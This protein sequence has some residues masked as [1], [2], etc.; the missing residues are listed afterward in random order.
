MSFM[1]SLLWVLVLLCSAA[2]LNAQFD[3]GSIVGTV[4]DVGGGVMPEV[5]ITLQSLGTGISKATLSNASGDYTFSSVPTGDYIVKASHVGFK[6]ASTSAFTVTVGARQ[7]VD[8]T[9]FPANVSQQ[10]IVTAAAALL[11]TDSS[12]RSMVINPTEVL[13]LPLNGRDPA[14]LALVVPGVNKS[15]LEIEGA[16]SREAAYNV[17]G[18]RKQVNS[19]LL[20]GLDNNSWSLN[21]LGF[22]NQET[23]LS[24]D[25]LSEF[26]FTTGNQNAEFGRAAGAIVNEVSKRGSN[27]YHGASW[28]YLR[29]T[30]LNANGPIPATNGQKPIL[31]QNQFGADIGGPIKRG[32]LFLFGD[33]E[34]FRQILRRPLLATVPTAAQASGQF[35][36]GSGKAIQITNPYTKAVYAN[37][38]IP[39]ANLKATMLPGSTTTPQISPLNI[40]VLGLLPTPQTGSTFTSFPLGTQDYDKGD[41]RMDYHIGPNM[42]TFA[43]YSQR[44]FNALDPA[45][46][47]APLSST[48]KGYINQSNKQLAAGFVFQ[49][50]TASALDL[51]A[52]FSWNAGAQRPISTGQPNLLVAAGEPNVPSDPSFASGLNTVAVTGFSQFG[53]NTQLP[54]VVN[55]FVADPKVNYSWL[56]GHHSFKFGYEYIH[57]SSLVS[58]FKPVFGADTYGGKFSQGS[59]KAGTLADGTVDPAYA[60]AWNLADFIFG[61]RSKYELS[62]RHQVECNHRMHFFYGQDDWRLTDKLTLNLGLRYENATPPFETN[63][64]LSNFDPATSPTGGLILAKGGSIYDRAL[65]RRNNLNFAPR[66]GLAYSLGSKMVVRGAYGISYQQFL[67]AA[68]VNELAQNAP[69]SI[70]NLITQYAPA[71]P[72]TGQAVCTSTSTSPLNCFQPVQLGYMTGFLSSSNYSALS[73][74]TNYDPA[75][76]PTTYVQSYQLSVQRQLTRSI[77]LDVGYVGNYGVHEQIVQDYNQA[78]PNVAGA[79]LSL[80]ARRPISTYG[81]IQESF[82]EGPSRYNALE[83][84]LEK[85]YSNGIYIANSFTWSHAQ[86]VAA[87]NQE[88]NNNDS[89]VVDRYDPMGTYTRSAYDRPLNDSLAVVAD[90]PFG[91]GRRFGG[92]ASKPLQFLLGDWQV[93]AL[94]Y[95]IS[96]LPINIT[97]AQTTAQQLS[98]ETSFLYRP[99]LKGNPVLSSGNRTSLGGGQYKYLDKSVIDIPDPTKVS[100]PYGN[101]SRNVARAPGFAD[102]DL[103]LHKRFPLGFE[104]VGL[105]F[106]AEAFDVLNR[107]NAQAPDSVATDLTYGIVSSYFP[108]REIQLALKLVF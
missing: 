22:S 40:T 53:R 21:D 32:K 84:K 14:D 89:P 74:T 35:V 108:P 101:C 11:E 92:S 106:R 49:L 61:A 1:R 13:N 44:R 55:P 60:L 93:T 68:V 95:L 94:N 5:Q 98:T 71:Y 9:F 83:A 96:G 66:F 36:D 86:D 10:T 107:S 78:V 18:L 48:A 43:R 46:I 26:R 80:Q 17:N 29:N 38:I 4:H 23:Q 82:N 79:T 8:L 12:D 67:R 97:Y 62:A 100:S 99:S 91:K 58:N 70:D 81:T 73:T 77:F 16:T 42:T 75:R 37:G 34:G 25:A 90:L 57:Q 104:K 85:R 24:P 50:T 103:G 27:E 39:V 69:Y 63:N 59:A 3:S 72:K 102:L 51:R 52:G 31:I 105:E 87:A 76:T 30:V 65:I 33:Y 88:L 19:F 41:A 7:R 47:P 2:L 56:K 28:D 54:T 15:F 45:P 64:Q 6:D 20:D